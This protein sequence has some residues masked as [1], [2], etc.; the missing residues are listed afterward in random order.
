MPIAIGSNED[1]NSRYFR[2]NDISYSRACIL[3]GCNTRGLLSL[4]LNRILNHL[5]HDGQ[6]AGHRRLLLLVKYLR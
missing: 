4:L 6:G 1:K 3:E 2:D 5:R